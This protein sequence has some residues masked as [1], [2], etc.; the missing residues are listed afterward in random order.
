MARPLGAAAVRETVLDAVQFDAR[1]A[2]LDEVVRQLVLAFGRRAAPAP[3][4]EVARMHRQQG[5]KNKPG[6]PPCESWAHLHQEDLRCSFARRIPTLR[7]C[8]N[9]L[10]GRW[11]HALRFALEARN[12][13]LGDFSACCQ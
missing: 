9:F 4:Q 2:L 11:R 5:R 8:P 13:L 3:P 7:A 1:V 6:E 12:F 10:R